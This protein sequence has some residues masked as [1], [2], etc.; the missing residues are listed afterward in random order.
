MRRLL[1]LCSIALALAASN[2][3]VAPAS[4]DGGPTPVDD[5]QVFAARVTGNLPTEGVALGLW[6]GGS[7]ETLDV[8]QPEI[9]SVWTTVGGSLL[10][11]L[12]GA[13]GFVNANFLAS[14]PQGQIDAGTPVLAVVVPAPPTPPGGSDSYSLATW[15]A[16]SDV[17][18]QPN[19]EVA[20]C[21]GCWPGYAGTTIGVTT[22]WTEEQ[23][24]DVFV[25]SGDAGDR[26]ALEAQLNDFQTRLGI[27]W[28]YVATPAAADFH[29]FMGFDR[30]NVPAAF[31]TWAL[32]SLAQ[33]ELI[34]QWSAF[35]TTSSSFSIGPNGID[36]A[37]RFD[38]DDAAVFVPFNQKNGDLIPRALL[39]T[40]IRHE[41]VHAIGWAEHW[42]VPGRLM[43]ASTSQEQFASELEWDM[44]SLL[45]DD[46]VMPGMYDDQILAAV[47]VGP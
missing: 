29:V 43:S 5:G 41:L 21:T 34:P 27:P 46:A 16:F 25:Y 30:Q 47:T 22:R 11:Y 9:S 10:G 23:V 40:N 13:P 1:A 14:Y 42:S 4:A 12:V 31:P 36:P 6:D 37:D 8:D 38:I 20:S 19:H 15:T 35:A 39:D 44:L 26:A 3:F 32:D 33:Q 2:G 7:V 17:L 18:L 28:Q 24:L 45:Y